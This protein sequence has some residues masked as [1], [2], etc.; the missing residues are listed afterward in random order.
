M[1]EV[2][3][4]TPLNHRGALRTADLAGTPDTIDLTTGAAIDL[5]QHARLMVGLITPV[6]GPRPFDFEIAAA[7]NLRF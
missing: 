3:V 5:W 4:N 6:S 2:H 7:L 1:F